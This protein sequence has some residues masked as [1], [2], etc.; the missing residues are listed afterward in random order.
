MN[1]VIL[2]VFAQSQKSR[3]IRLEKQ[4]IVIC[5]VVTDDVSVDFF[6]HL[7]FAM[8]NRPDNKSTFIVV[9]ISQLN[10]QNTNEEQNDRK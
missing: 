6:I 8:L 9:L 3:V 1:I 7:S 4:I 10:E 5:N 2:L